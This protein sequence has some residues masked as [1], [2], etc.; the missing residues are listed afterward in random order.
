[1]YFKKGEIIS[2]RGNISQEKVETEIIKFNIKP[3]LLSEF[4]EMSQW[5]ITENKY[6]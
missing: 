5:E 4:G 2:E 3:K 1:M 6:L